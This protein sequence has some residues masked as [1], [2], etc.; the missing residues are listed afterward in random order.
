ME[1]EIVARYWQALWAELRGEDVDLAVIGQWPREGAAG[2]SDEVEDVEARLSVV[3]NKGM[4]EAAVSS[5]VFHVE[6]EE[7][8]LP[9][10]LDLFYWTYSHVVNISPTEGWLEEADHQLVIASDI[11]ATDGRRLSQPF[12]LNFSTRPD[13]AGIDTSATAC[14]C[15][16]ARSSGS[17]W[18]LTLFGTVVLVL[19][20]RRP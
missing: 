18:L 19:T 14:G 4:Y 13:T 7:Q 6:S 2:H 11:E 15:T 20:R 10:E 17:T 3:F 5:R 1:A 8:E 9:I 16:T 12:T